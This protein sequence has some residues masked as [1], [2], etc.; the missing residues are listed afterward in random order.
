MLNKEQLKSLQEQLDKI[1]SLEYD[2]EIGAANSGRFEDDFHKAISN[3]K[4]ILASDKISEK[5][6]SIFDN[7]FANK[8]LW[9]TIPKPGSMPSG[10]DI[11]KLNDLKAS[12]ENIIRMN[13]SFDPNKKEWNF[14][15]GDIFKAKRF[16][17]EIFKKATSNIK[18]IDN[19]LDEEIFDYLGDLDD[20]LEV[21][22]VTDGKIK[23]FP[24][25]YRAYIVDHPK[26]E[27]KINNQSHDRFIMIDDQE[28]FALGASLNTIGKKDFMVHKIE[29]EEEKNKKIQDFENYWTKGIPIT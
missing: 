12:V 27:A 19:Y 7:L 20:I 23:M 17:V 5:E 14:S 22:M 9:R 15:A 4:S 1:A 21:K 13:A 3:I 8:Y 2:M 24:I 16:I 28:I 10:A 25:L 29:S 18:I 26:T 11:N 6:K